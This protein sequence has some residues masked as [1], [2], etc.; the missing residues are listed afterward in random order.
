MHCGP[1]QVLPLF[2]MQESF[3]VPAQP[4]I[5]L[6]FIRKPDVAQMPC[7]PP[8]VLTY[9]AGFPIPTLLHIR[10]DL[11]VL[12]A[13]NRNTM[14][15]AAISEMDAPANVASVRSLQGT[16]WL[17]H[18]GQMAFMAP[19]PISLT[20][21]NLEA[22]SRSRYDVYFMLND[23][24]WSVLVCK[25]PCSPGDLSIKINPSQFLQDS[26]HC[27][28]SSQILLTKLCRHFACV[29]AT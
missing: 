6:D 24:D 7:T 2:P 20:S 16:I 4:N 28:H 17:L 26:Y 21:C 9:N 14:V 23:V 8:L 12:T 15:A 29:H 10:G 22:H 27:A 3:P 13:S 25:T 11:V 19:S 18:Q 1:P 5:G